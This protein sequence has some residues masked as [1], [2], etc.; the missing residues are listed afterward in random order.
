MTTKVPGTLIID[1]SI[2]STQLGTASVTST[3]VGTGAIVEA[4]YAATSIPTAAYKV[5]SVN[6]VALGASAVT[7]AKIAAAA[8]IE[9][10]YGAVS[11]PSGA[12]KIGS[13]G[14][15]ALADRAVTQ[16][17]HA[18]LS[19]GTPELIDGSVTRLKL[20]ASAV[21]T[22]E[23]EDF[24][25]TPTDYVKGTKGDIFVATETDGTWTRVPVGTADSVLAVKNGLPT[26]S[27]NILPAGV[28]MDYCGIA[29]PSGWVLANGRTI[30]NAASGATGRAN[31]DTSALFT[32]LWDN[33]ADAQAA[34]SGGRGASATADFSANKTIALPD[35]RGRMSAGRDN[36]EATS[37]NRLTTA[38]ATAGG[39]VLGASG[40][41][42]THILTAAQLPAHKHYTVTDNGIDQDLASGATSAFPSTTLSI[43]R[44]GSGSDRNYVLFADGAH[45]TLTPTKSP[46]SVIGSGTAHSN[47][48]P[49]LVVSKIVKL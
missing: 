30:G 32:V 29:A 5:G 45:P 38:T 37:T 28:M 43:H 16:I 21:G 1:G 35:L 13:I 49:F 24:S 31:A 11:I 46:T 18:L 10:H 26:W 42:E 25:I 27:G 40:G 48:S 36:M 19:V 12:Y 44:R 33:F 23:I 17:K 20:A 9:N 22:T 34:V 3:K 6:D 14:T 47:M 41:S 2:T 8:I 39:N 15:T 4:A 7:S